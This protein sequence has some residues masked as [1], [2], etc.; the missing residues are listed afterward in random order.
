MAKSLENN[1]QKVRWIKVI[2]FL[3]DHEVVTDEMVLF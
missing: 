2:F 3:K 1:T